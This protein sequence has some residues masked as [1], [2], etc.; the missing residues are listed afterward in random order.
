MEKQ[1]F[2]EISENVFEKNG[3]GEFFV[4][5]NRDK[6]FSLCNIMLEIGRAHV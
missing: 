6:F 3:V 5:E 4:G 2:F 1:E